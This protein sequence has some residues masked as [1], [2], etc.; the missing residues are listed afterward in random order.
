MIRIKNIIFS[1]LLILVVSL[2]IFSDVVE[3]AKKKRKVKQKIS[4][5]CSV[6]E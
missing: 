3:A 6:F 4:I 5:D 1:I 2:F